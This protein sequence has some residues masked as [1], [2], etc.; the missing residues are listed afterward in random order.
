MKRILCL[1]MALCLL[2]PVV[3]MA[4]EAPAAKIGMAYGACHSHGVTVAT[5]VVVD[6]VIVDALLDEV[7]ITNANDSFVALPNAEEVAVVDDATIILISKRQNNDAYSANMIARGGQAL[8][9][10][11]D[12]IQA[13]VIGKTVEEL[14]AAVEGYT[15]DNKADFIDVVS[16]STITDTLKYTLVL[17]E[18]AKNAQ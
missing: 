17:L 8:A 9:T 11:Y 7:Y 6:G 15:E 12:A 13:F 16:G 2:L 18:A 1:L 10:S 5:V 4:E 3:A 14:E